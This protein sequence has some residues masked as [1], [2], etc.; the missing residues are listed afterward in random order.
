MKEI[1]F[2][3]KFTFKISTLSNDFVARDSRGATL[4]YVR[5]K[6]FKLKESV[7]VYGNEDRHQLLYTIKANKWL[8]FSAAYAITDA[9]GTSVGKVARKGWRSIWKAEYH[10]INPQDQVQYKVRE[11]SIWTRMAD[12]VVG[13]IPVLGFF[14]GYLFH[15]V[16]EVRDTAGNVVMELKKQPSFFGRQ[17][18]LEQI[19][20]LPDEDDTR[21]V[22][23]LMMMVLLER[24]RG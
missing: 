18:T 22:L 1:S 21:V 8:D 11:R 13:D 12:N 15:P 23:G 6:M 16:Y 14:T 7:N 20:D 19:E 3:V 9:A 4:A 10:I 24:Q 5:Q 2:P 17:F